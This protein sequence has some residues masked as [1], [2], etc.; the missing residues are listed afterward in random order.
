MPDL[1][2][3]EH[4]RP[5]GRPFPWVCP[6]CRQKQVRLATIPYRAERLSNGKLIA[7]DIP[8]L[9]V[10]QCDHCGELVFNYPAE[11]QILRAVTAKVKEVNPGV[12]GPNLTDNERCSTREGNTCQ[13]P[14]S[15]CDIEKG[16]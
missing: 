16:S 8:E 5:T 13:E 3:N 9:S 7:V 4:L 1:A 14:F 15:R 6:K 10:P 2:P 12:N 11:E